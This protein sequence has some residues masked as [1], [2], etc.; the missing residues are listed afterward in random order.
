MKILL[1]SLDFGGHHSQGEVSCV[2]SSGKACILRVTV[3]VM[4]R[5]LNSFSMSQ[6]HEVSFFQHVHHCM[7]RGDVYVVEASHQCPSTVYRMYATS[8]V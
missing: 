6:F 3:A 5:A 1:M 7:G 8:K 2:V 4:G